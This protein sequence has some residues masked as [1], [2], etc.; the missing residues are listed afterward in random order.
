MSVLSA[1]HRCQHW[2]TEVSIRWIYVP[3]Y[4]MG[5]DRAPVG[6]YAVALCAD[7]ERQ[8]WQPIE[9]SE[10]KLHWRQQSA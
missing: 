8:G 10:R 7:C 3:R 1:C 2:S 4:A 6:T 5:A 9:W